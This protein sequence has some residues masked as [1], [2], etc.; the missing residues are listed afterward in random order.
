MLRKRGIEVTPLQD[1]WVRERLTVPMADLLTDIHLMF[2]DGRT[3]RGAE[4]YR[5]IMRRVWWLVP[6]YVLS[7]LPGV[8]DAFDW[9]YR[10]FADN[11]Y[12]ISKACKLPAGDGKGS[13]V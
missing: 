12:R 5:F 7:T 9:G 1:P 10:K 2:E 3:I 4:V 8:R 11:R 6:I 13:H